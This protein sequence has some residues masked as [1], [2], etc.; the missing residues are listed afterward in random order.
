[1]AWKWAPDL[2]FS[3]VISS[4]AGAPVV[5]GRDSINARRCCMLALPGRSM[6]LS[7]V[8]S[9]SPASFL[10]AGNFSECMDQME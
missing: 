6:A 5:K 7:Q 10:G 4:C 8:K 1:M 3:L 9:I 2:G